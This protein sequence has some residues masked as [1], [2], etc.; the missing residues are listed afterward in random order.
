M[1]LQLL[2]N[3]NYS[4]GADYIAKPMKI[5]DNEERNNLIISM[6]FLRLGKL[7]DIIV[8]DH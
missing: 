5:M 3:R 7:Y 6:M 1:K 2:D 4:W 8:G